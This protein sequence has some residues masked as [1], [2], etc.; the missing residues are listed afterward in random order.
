MKMRKNAYGILKN[1]QKNGLNYLKYNFA[2]ARC[3]K[4]MHLPC[5]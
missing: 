1:L 3:C 2:R 5:I 4:K